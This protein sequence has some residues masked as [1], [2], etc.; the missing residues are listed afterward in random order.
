MG[1][2]SAVRIVLA[3]VTALGL[4]ITYMSAIITP[5]E[6]WAYQSLSTHSLL[7]NRALLQYLLDDIVILGRAELALQLAL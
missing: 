6:E 7:N 5:T 2:H 3:A 4:Q 1:Y